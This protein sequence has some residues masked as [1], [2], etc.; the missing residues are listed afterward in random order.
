VANA[1]TGLFWRFHF[2]VIHDH[3]A[4]AAMHAGGSNMAKLAMFYQKTTGALAQR[5]LLLFTWRPRHVPGQLPN[6]LEVIHKN[7]SDWFYK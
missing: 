2:L 4:T 6:R 3:P 7:A 1:N 5:G